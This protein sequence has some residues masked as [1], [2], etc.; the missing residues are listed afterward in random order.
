MIMLA[1]RDAN[2]NVSIIIFIFAY[3]DGG[4]CGGNVSIVQPPVP[5]GKCA[6]FGLE[7][8]GFADEYVI[9]HTDLP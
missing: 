8:H 2:G 3:D 7:R 9:S 6:L 1:A 4:V 5:H